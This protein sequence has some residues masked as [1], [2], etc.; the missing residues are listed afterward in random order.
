VLHGSAQDATQASAFVTVVGDGVG[1]V[2]S[3]SR[4]YA[5]LG[6]NLVLWATTSRPRPVFSLLSGSTIEKYSNAENVDLR[7]GG[8]R[9]QRGDHLRGGV[10]VAGAAAL[11]AEGRHMT[12]DKLV[13]V[14]VRYQDLRHLHQDRPHVASWF[15]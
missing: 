12:L 3:S 15:P 11:A 6:S 5:R 14:V 9:P 7:S 8:R 10:S 4:A 2:A 13:A 1:V